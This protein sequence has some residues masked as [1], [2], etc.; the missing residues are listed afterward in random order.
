VD[1]K[2]AVFGGT[3]AVAPLWAA[4]IALINEQLGK[5]VGFLNTTLYAKG[6]GALRDI[7]VGTNGAYSAGAGWDA[8]TGLGSPGGQALLTAL[9]GK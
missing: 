6:P 9:K 8:C 3:S 2:N 4:L 5:P 7:T 1:G